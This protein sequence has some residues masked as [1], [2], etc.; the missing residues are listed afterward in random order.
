MMRAIIQRGT[1][2]LESQADEVVL[3]E[4]RELATTI[5]SDLIDTASNELTRHAFR[6][7]I[8]LISA[9][10]INYGKRIFVAK[11]PDEETGIAEKVAASFISSFQC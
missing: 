5:V 3:P 2:I 10:Q 9:P 8:G 4:E 11:L 7:G 1:A 6:K